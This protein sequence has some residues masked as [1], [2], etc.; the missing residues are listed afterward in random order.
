L[1]Y[2]RVGARACVGRTGDGGEVTVGGRSGQG[3]AMVR[4]GRSPGVQARRG[5]G[6]RRSPAPAGRA[7]LR[8]RFREPSDL[9]CAVDPA[10]H[11]EA[12]ARKPDPELRPQPRRSS[13]RQARG[14]SGWLGF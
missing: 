7:S 2:G 6:Q 3:R 13:R 10:P 1:S 4:H 9:S 5:N 8:A 11:G 14:L 12:P